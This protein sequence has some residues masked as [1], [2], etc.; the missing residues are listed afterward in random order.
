M[1]EYYNALCDTIKGRSNTHR[2]GV[3]PVSYW[4][5]TGEVARKN[6]WARQFSGEFCLHQRAVLLVAAACLFVTAALEH[7]KSDESL[8]QLALLAKS[9]QIGILGIATASHGMLFEIGGREL[10]NLDGV[11]R[12]FKT[13]ETATGGRPPYRV[14]RRYVFRAE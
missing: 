11:F 7:T 13:V 9:R 3:S 8:V 10:S 14:S 2:I 4:P 6:L 1:F 12:R 5:G